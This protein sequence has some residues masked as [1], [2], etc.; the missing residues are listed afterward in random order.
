MPVTSFRPV[1]PPA[2]AAFCSSCIRASVS[3]GEVRVACGVCAG[4]SEHRVE[5]EA[6]GRG[7]RAPLTV[8][9]IGGVAVGV[10]VVVVE[11]GAVVVV[12]VPHTSFR[13]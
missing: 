7:A 4:K 1:R 3:T 6:A 2:A 8:P 9:A 5:V 13:C 12:V 10:V 11:D